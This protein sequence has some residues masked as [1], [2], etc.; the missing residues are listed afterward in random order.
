[1]NLTLFMYKWESEIDTLHR[2]WRRLVYNHIISFCFSILMSSSNF[3]ETFDSVVLQALFWSALR[4]QQSV[5]LP[6]MSPMFLIVDG[7]GL[8]EGRWCLYRIRTWQC[9]AE[10]TQLEK[11]NQLTQSSNG[12]LGTADLLTWLR[13][14]ALLTFSKLF[15]TILLATF[16]L[17]ND[18]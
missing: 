15:S 17:H 14:S 10:N 11:G 5:T 2:F 8:Q 1:M 4:A 9:P 18:D 6:L 7:S 13:S 3:S 12:L 16:K